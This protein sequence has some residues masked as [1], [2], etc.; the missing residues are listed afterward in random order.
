MASYHLSASIIGRSEGRSAIAAAAYRSGAALS[1]PVSGKAH[2]YTRKRGVVSAEIMLPENAPAWAA[3]RQS[4][5]ASVEAKEARVNSR[6][7]REIRLAL[8]DEL[9]EAGRAELVRAWVRDNITAQG[10]AADVAIHAPGAEGDQRNHHAHIMTTCRRF[11][12]DRHDGWSKGAARDLNEVAFLEGLRSSW[13]EA[14]NEAL[15]RAGSSAA[16]D[17]RSLT[18]Q[19][20]EA[21]T[22]GD[23]LL[24]EALDR[25]PEPRL[26]VAAAAIDRAAGA[27]VTARGLAL[28]EARATRSALLDALDR[29]RQA[30][31]V[32]AR[33]QERAVESVQS[34]W[35]TLTAAPVKTPARAQQ[36]DHAD[37]FTAPDQKG[38]GDPAETDA[39]DEAAAAA[40]APDDDT[41]SPT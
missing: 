40:T 39:P 9:D 26:G 28:A 34:I 11:D 20:D 37:P 1:D 12:P 13:A 41:P 30:G 5:W 21:L 35:A 29:A 2:D 22:I 25:P 33:L 7:S 4:L 27:P 6:L 14:Q 23:D 32:L 16:V 36:I 17:H 19:R 8:P 15:A 31:A 18:A 38:G 3:D 10:I 24:A